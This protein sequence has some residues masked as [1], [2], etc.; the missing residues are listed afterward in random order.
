MGSTLPDKWKVALGLS[1]STASLSRVE[2][3]AQPARAPRT[4]TNWWE[5][6]DESRDPEPLH[7]KG[8]YK[9]GTLLRPLPGADRRTEGK[10]KALELTA[11]HVKSS[12]RMD[13][14]ARSHV[15]ATAS[16]ED[17]FENGWTFDQVRAVVDELWHAGLE[18]SSPLSAAHLVQ[19]Q[20]LARARAETN[21]YNQ[22]ERTIQVLME[23]GWPPDEASKVARKL[24]KAGLPHTSPNG[25]ANRMIAKQ[26][27]RRRCTREQ[28]A[29]H[30]SKMES[31]V[32]DKRRGTKE[33]KGVWSR[34]ELGEKEM[35]AVKNLH[36][37]EDQA[38]WVRGGKGEPLFLQVTREEAN[39]R[40]RKNEEAGKIYDVKSVRQKEAQLPKEIRKEGE[41]ATHPRER[42]TLPRRGDTSWNRRRDF[43]SMCVSLSLSLSLSLF[44]QAWLEKEKRRKDRPLSAQPG[45]KR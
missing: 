2:Q 34:T 44:L 28:L 15:L 43:T 42:T 17:L 5:I 36:R 13:A 25:N 31:D 24:W 22:Q 39:E 7:K 14:E 3:L 12:A 32:I 27:S 16:A 20:K 37:E 1:A 11:T 35:K 8:Y 21:Q 38:V 10:L 19:A 23:K 9:D 33:V 45:T 29:R 6:K 40:G 18:W 4:S 30:M 41:K 26:M